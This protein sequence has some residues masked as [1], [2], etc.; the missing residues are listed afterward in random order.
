MNRAAG[1]F[2]LAAVWWLGACASP[3]TAQVTYTMADTTVTD[4]F[5]ELTDSGGE[6]DAYGNNENFTFT[7]D[8]GSPLDLQFLGPIDIEPAAPGTGLLFDYLIL[9]DG[10][11]TGRRCWTPCMATSRIRRATPP[12]AR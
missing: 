9:Y 12:P 3:L 7:V 8:A 11:N 4:C 10:P 2:L 6:D 1:P 5:G